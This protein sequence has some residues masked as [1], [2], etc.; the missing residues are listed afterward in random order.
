LLY[1]LRYVIDLIGAEHVG[2]SLDYVF[3]QSDLEQ[4][5]RLH[6]ELYAPGTDPGAPTVEPEAMGEIAEGLAHDNLTDAQIR[7]ILGENWL[8]IATQVWR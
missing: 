8:R 4:S 2:L 1:Q 7:G 5:V 6:P 3:D